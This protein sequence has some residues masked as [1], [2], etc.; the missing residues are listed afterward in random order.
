MC[1]RD[2]SDED[3]EITQK[4]GTKMEKETTIQIR[5]IWMRYIRDE[6]AKGR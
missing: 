2:A 1:A 3:K 5:Y 4:K 6:G